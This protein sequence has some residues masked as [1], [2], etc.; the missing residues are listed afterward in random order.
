MFYEKT[1]ARWDLPKRCCKRRRF[2]FTKCWR[3]T[4]GKRFT[5]THLVLCS[6]AR[7][8]NPCNHITL[9]WDRAG[10]D[11]CLF[12]YKLPRNYYKGLGIPGGWAFSDKGGT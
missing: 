2:Y 5:K 11:V 1:L 8:I 7:T 3:K 6:F 10:F 12:W 4:G 9:E